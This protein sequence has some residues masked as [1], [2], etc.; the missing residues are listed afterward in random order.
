M[1]KNILMFSIDRK[2][3]DGFS[4][5]CKD[6]GS[7]YQKQH[8]MG[9]T[10][11]VKITN[12]KCSKCNIIKTVGEYH[13]SKACSD[14]LKSQCKSCMKANEKIQIHCK[15]FKRLRHFLKD[16]KKSNH[17]FDYIQCSKPFLIEWL[18]YIFDKQF[19]NYHLQSNLEPLHIDHI[20]PLFYADPSKEEDLYKFWCWKNL[21]IC[22]LP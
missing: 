4:N 19:P 20:Y 18:K 8:R 10:G 14:G 7:I 17:T 12:K 6:C 13:H 2:T 16:N 3:R 1:V 15:L 11:E 5:L 21:H 9:Y 22:P